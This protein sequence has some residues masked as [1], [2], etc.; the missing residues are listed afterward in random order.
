MHLQ[1]LYI[2]VHSVTEHPKIRIQLRTHNH[3]S[4]IRTY[5]LAIAFLTASF[6]STTAF[7]CSRL[8]KYNHS[9]IAISTII[10]YLHINQQ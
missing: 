4:A 7:Y 6:C 9:L 5:A 10:I 3:H 2:T 1:R 8:T